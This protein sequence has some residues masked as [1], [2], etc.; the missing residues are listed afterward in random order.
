MSVLPSNHRPGADPPKPPTKTIEV[1]FL[2][3]YYT[4][5]L[6]L[7]YFNQLQHTRLDQSFSP[8]LLFICSMAGVCVAPECNSLLS[9]TND[10]LQYEGLE[11]G[12]DYA[13]SK[14][15]VR[16]IW[17]TTKHPRPSM[18]QY[19]SNLL[20]PT[21]VSKKK[22]AGESESKL[23]DVNRTPLRDMTMLTVPSTTPRRTNSPTLSL[24]HCDVSAMI[25]SR[26]RLSLAFKEVSGLLAPSILTFATTWLEGV[27]GGSCWIKLRMCGC[28][29]TRHSRRTRIV[30]FSNLSLLAFVVQ[31]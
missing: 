24:L 10:R 21:Y 19:Q 15:G 11:F 23:R 12:T 6:A 3:V 31:V 17:K 8:Q 27:V 2:G 29:R 30:V 14:H 4:T 26:E 1:S 20:A 9:R 22:I 7:W 28:H 5:S 25:P 18:A 13:A 16:A